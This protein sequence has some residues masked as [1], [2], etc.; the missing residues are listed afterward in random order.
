MQGQPMFFRTENGESYGYTL[1]GKIYIDPRVATA[2]TPVHEYVHLW[3][4]ALRKA[5]PKAWARLSEQILGKKDVLEYVKGLYPELEGDA[6]VEEVFAHFA[7]RRG[8]ERLRSEQER[9]TQEAGGVFE[10]A[11][12]VSIFDT[13]RRALNDFFRQARDLFAGKVKGISKLSAEDFADMAM[14]DLVNGVKPE[15]KER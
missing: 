6:L 8:A 14:S 9:M 3:A 1:N 13:I 15:T 10:K 5:N 12:V 2:E 11:K 4:E 7:G